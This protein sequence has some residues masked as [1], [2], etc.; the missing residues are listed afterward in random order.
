[1]R[2]PYSKAYRAFPELDRF[3]DAECEG[4]V[5]LVKRQYRFAEVSVQLASVPLMLIVTAPGVLLV[6][7]LARWQDTSGWGESWHAWEWII[8]FG[9]LLSGSCG[10]LSGLMFYDCWLKRAILVRLKEAKCPA[11]AYSLLGLAV[12]DGGIRCPECGEVFGLAERGLTPA[13]LLASVAEAGS[14]AP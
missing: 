3:S 1:M 12:V 11:C 13:D 5:R 4:F 2:I 9:A 8:L 7:A 6:M 10:G 14:G